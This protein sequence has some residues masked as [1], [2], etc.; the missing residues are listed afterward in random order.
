MERPFTNIAHI[1]GFDSPITGERTGFPGIDVG[2]DSQ[3]W[4]NQRLPTKE[5]RR[6]SR[7]L[8][9]C[10]VSMATMSGGAVIDV[11]SIDGPGSW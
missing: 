2:L 10:V 8:A 3:R 4:R 6:I 1:T 11:L 9:L 7:E 5:H